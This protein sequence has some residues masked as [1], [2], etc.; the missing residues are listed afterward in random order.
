MEKCFRVMI[1]NA[2]LFSAD[3]ISVLEERPVLY[4]FVI[5]FIS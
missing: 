3:S 1:V 2:F 4:L 5:K